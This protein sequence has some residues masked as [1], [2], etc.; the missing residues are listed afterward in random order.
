MHLLCLCSLCFLNVFVLCLVGFVKLTSDLDGISSY[1]LSNDCFDTCFVAISISY[2]MYFVSFI[3]ICRGCYVLMHGG[4]HNLLPF[5][6]FQWYPSLHF[7]DHFHFLF[8]FM[9]A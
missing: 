2:R 7:C 1:S 4:S 5:G 3:S 9:L 6:A 8:C